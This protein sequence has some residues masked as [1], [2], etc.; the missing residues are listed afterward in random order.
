M[1]LLS[2]LVLQI[3]GATG[4]EA[5]PNVLHG[6]WDNNTK[7]VKLTEILPTRQ[8]ISTSHFFSS[9]LSSPFPISLF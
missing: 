7:K 5:N 9:S 6:K 3:Y 8:G 2:S 1:L 4:T